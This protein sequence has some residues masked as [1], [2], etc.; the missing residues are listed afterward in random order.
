MITIFKLWIL[1]GKNHMTDNACRLIVRKSEINL[2]SNSIKFPNSI[3][4]T[5]WFAR[6]FIS[7]QINKQNRKWH[8]TAN[9]RYTKSVRFIWSMSVSIFRQNIYTANKN[10]WD[11]ALRISVYLRYCSLCAMWFFPGPRHRWMQASRNPNRIW[12][13]K[14][15]DLDD[16]RCI[17][18]HPFR[19]IYCTFR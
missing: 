4:A 6:A 11:V 8:Q 3:T 12:Y 1:C 19:S 17:D 15:R 9:E 5:R 13:R 16:T 14:W 10:A 18:K 7:Q 2:E